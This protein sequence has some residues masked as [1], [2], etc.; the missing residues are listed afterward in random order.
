MNHIKTPVSLVELA[1]ASDLYDSEGTLLSVF[2][3]REIAQE[4]A[5]ALNAR[6]ALVEVCKAAIA[7]HAQHV[8]FT[9]PV[10]LTRLA[11]MAEA[12]LAKGEV[13]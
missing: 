3:S 11:E 1:D 13:T 7:F 6:D 12:A 2:R 9:A 5:A 8:P 10:T 4:V